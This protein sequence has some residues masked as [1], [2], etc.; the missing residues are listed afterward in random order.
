MIRVET[1]IKG[2]NHFPFSSMSI[3]SGQA[4]PKVKARHPG[5]L[6]PMGVRELSLSGSQLVFGCAYLLGAAKLLFWAVLKLWLFEW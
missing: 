1:T 2:S 4:S 3:S 6:G 5:L